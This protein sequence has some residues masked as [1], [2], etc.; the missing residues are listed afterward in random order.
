M[1]TPGETPSTSSGTTA[2]SQAAASNGPIV[3]PEA[4]SAAGSEEWDSWLSHFVDCSVINEWSDHRKAQFLAVRMRGAALLQLQSLSPEVRGDYTNLKRALCEKFIPKERIELHKAEFRARRRER[5]EKLP[6]LASSLRRLVGKAYLE[7]VVDLQDSLAKDQFIDALED[8]E[9]RMKIRELGPKTLDEAVSRALQIEAMYEAESRRTKSRSVQV[10]QEPSQEEKNDLLELLKQNTAA[11]NQMVQLVQK[12]QQRPSTSNENGRK[13][14]GRGLGPASKDHRERRC[15]RC[16]NLFSSVHSVS[17]DTAVYVPGLVGGQPVDM[18]VDTGSAVTLV[19]QR[20]LDRS[21]KNFQLSVV[22]EPVVVSANGQPL[23]IRGKCDLQICVDGVNV[24]H[25]VLVAADVTQNCL[26]GMDFLGKHGCTIDFKTSSLSFGSSVVKLKAKSG[27]TKVYYDYKIEHRPGRKHQNADALS[28]NP[29]LVAEETDQ[30]VQTSAVDSSTS[31]WVP[32]WTTGDLQSRQAADPDLNEILAWKQNQTNQPALQEMQSTSK[33]TKSLW[34]QWNR[35]Q[36]ENGVLYRRWETEDGRGA[37]LQLVLPRSLVQE[38]LSAL[39]DA[40]SAGHLGVNKTLERVRE[41][42]YWYGQQHDIEDWCRQCEKYNRRKPPHQPE[43]ASEYVRNLRS[44][45]DE[46]HERAREHLRTAQRRQKDYYDRRVAGKEIKV[47]DHVYLPVPAIKTGQTK[48][49]H[50]PWQ[51]PHMVVKKISD[52]TYRIEE[53]A[54][55][56][57]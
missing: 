56:R 36:L 45:L 28:R 31:A 35:L 40:P 37:R 38:V 16:N 52:V 39:H 24:V 26:L 32:T 18:L 57:K 53:V 11:M 30:A 7:V 13:Q 17:S 29:L 10:V 9:I 27:V 41:R 3:M 46:A 42:F 22:G 54:N 43:A 23:N 6:D 19:H 55:C 51:G 25:S 15:F 21:P 8:R 44:T 2:S 34:A 47:G 33:A 14:H 48:K 5:D 12:Q 49:F 50:L 20:V 4:F 1:T